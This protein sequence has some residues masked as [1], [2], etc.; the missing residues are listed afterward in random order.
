MKLTH[1]KFIK[2]TKIWFLFSGIL[3]TLGVGAMINNQ[4]RYGQFMKLGIDFTGGT[5]MELKFEQPVDKGTDMLKEVINSAVAENTVSQVTQTEQGTFI[6]HAKDLTSEQYDSAVAAVKDKMGAFD[7]VQFTTIGPTIGSSLKSKAIIAVVIAMI[8]IVLYLAYAFRKVPKRV[9]PWKFGMCAIG[10][11]VHDVLITAGVFAFFN[12]EIDAFFITAILTVIGFSVHDT[13]VVFD[14]I[15]EN[16][17]NQGRDDSFADIADISL[18]QTLGRSIN[19]SLST[20]FTLTAL[21]I[22]GA[23]SI[24]LFTFALIIGITIGT[25]SSIFIASPMLTLWQERSRVR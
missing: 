5:L 6:V 3:I 23:D 15:R 7:Q 12:Y 10:A 16:L 4:I 19:T 20:L 11:L 18:N 21:F 2:Y 1:F 24:K 22:F 14:R 8:C 17:K 25:Y 13:I 9:S